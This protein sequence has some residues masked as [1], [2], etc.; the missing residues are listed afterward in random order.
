MQSRDAMIRRVSLF[1]PS[2]GRTP[3]PP[4]RATGAV[5]IILTGMLGAAQKRRYDDMRRLYYPQ[6]RQQ[7]GAHITLFHHLPPSILT[8]LSSLIRQMVAQMAPPKAYVERVMD[9][10]T[11]TAFFIRSP[12][13]LDIR[14]H[15]ADHFQ[16][17]VSAQDRGV[18]R[19]HITVQN[20]V[21]RHQAAALQREL[22]RDFQAHPLDIMGL[23]AHHYRDGPW[24]PAFQAAF[25]GGLP[26]G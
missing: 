22:R 8:E 5:P 25:R 6:H 20:K 4:V 19:L 2:V 7:V 18:P 14:A 13:L 11:G 12:E 1:S 21:S 15:I 16:G 24:E 17:M 23:E 10:G 3:P 26:G 9:L